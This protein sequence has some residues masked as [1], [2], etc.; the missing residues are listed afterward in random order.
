MLKRP[1]TLK[2]PATRAGALQSG[3][4]GSV[5][6]WK[7]D[8]TQG[9]AAADATGHGL[10]GRVQGQPRWAP[11]QGRF[12]G[13][14]ELDGATGFVD[15][16]DAQEFDFREGMSLSVWFKVRRFDKMPPVL[17]TK[18]NNTWQLQFTGDQHR[19]NFALTGPQTKGTT[20]SRSPSV[21]SNRALDDGQWH[22][23]VGAYD[24]QR[25]AL[26]VDGK[27]ADSMSASG[28]IAQNTEPVMIGGSPTTR[29]RPF[30][31]W[32]DDVRLYSCGLRESAIQALYRGITE[33]ADGTR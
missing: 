28:L 9:G 7:F 8:E 29:S 1:L 31:G 13:A 3:T 18:G 22:H 23:V 10:A 11:G 25:V 26:Y 6:W 17:V 24:G 12:G 32:I 20:R 14:L 5:A 16:A 27:L 19:L 30:E 33:T 15:C 21:T 4:E 2:P